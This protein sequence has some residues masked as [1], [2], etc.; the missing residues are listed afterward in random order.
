MLVESRVPGELVDE[1]VMRSNEMLVPA[2]TEPSRIWF[3][4]DV[5]NA[6]DQLMLRALT[7]AVDELAAGAAC[8]SGRSWGQVQQIV[9]A[10]PLAHHRGDARRF[11]VGPF[12]RAGYAET[13]M[14]TS[15][16]AAGCACGRVVQRRSSMLA[17]W[18]RSIATECPRAVGIARQPALRGSRRAVGRGGVFPAGIH[19]GC[20]ERQR[21]VDADARATTINAET[22]EPAEPEI[23]LRVSAHSLTC[24]SS[25][26]TAG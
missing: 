12:E 7:A 1:F 19:R 10:H 15:G 8:E 13:L 4:G 16:R 6:R 9:F 20:R 5:V 26:T 23:T 2:L 14:S 22:A 18:D 25:S 21:E 24:R 3:D 17:D 11:N